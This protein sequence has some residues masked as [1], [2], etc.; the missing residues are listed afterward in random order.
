MELIRNRTDTY[1]VKV[2]R[3]VL[4]IFKIEIPAV[5]KGVL[6]YLS[7]SGLSIS[8]GSLSLTLVLYAICK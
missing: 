1:Y 5:H 6:T 4:S 8:I 7:I 3:Q 2:F